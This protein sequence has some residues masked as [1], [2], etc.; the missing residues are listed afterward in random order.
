MCQPTKKYILKGTYEEMEL[1]IS[2]DVFKKTSKD[3]SKVL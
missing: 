3:E 1:F 2:T